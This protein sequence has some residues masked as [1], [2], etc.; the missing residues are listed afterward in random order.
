[1]SIQCF[2]SLLAMYYL[3]EVTDRFWPTYFMACVGP[4]SQTHREAH[5]SADLA[6]PSSHSCINSRKGEQQRSCH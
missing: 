5:E 4:W 6:S 1:M 2:R 3:P